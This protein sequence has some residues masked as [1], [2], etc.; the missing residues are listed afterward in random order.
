MT[1]IHYYMGSE[2]LTTGRKVIITAVAWNSLDL[3]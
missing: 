2:E 1:L 3:Y